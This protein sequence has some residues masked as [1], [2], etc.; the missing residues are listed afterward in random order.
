MKQETCGYCD[1]PQGTVIGEKEYH[2]ERWI[3]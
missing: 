2:L 1:Q 3:N